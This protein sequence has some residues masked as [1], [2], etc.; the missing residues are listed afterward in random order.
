M[1]V[2]AGCELEAE[3]VGVRGI[4]EWGQFMAGLTVPDVVD[5]GVVWGRFWAQGSRAFSLP[6]RFGGAETDGV[7]ERRSTYG[8]QDRAQRE[9]KA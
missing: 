2:D 3:G 1:G 6:V 5:E 9:A 7:R 8:R 4:A